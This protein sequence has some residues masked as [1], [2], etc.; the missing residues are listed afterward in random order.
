METLQ[1]RLPKKQITRLDRE[2]K[3]GEYRSRSEAIRVAL[4][5]LSFLASMDALRDILRKG[6]LGEKEGLKELEKIRTE[7]Y[8]KYI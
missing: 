1:I 4:E 5:K 2:V 7:I 6:G 8:R 3:G